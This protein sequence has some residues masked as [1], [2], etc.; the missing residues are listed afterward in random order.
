MLPAPLSQADRNHPQTLS[1]GGDPAPANAP[2]RGLQPVPWVFLEADLPRREG[3]DDQRAEQSQGEALG[4]VYQ[5]C[6]AGGE[7]GRMKSHTAGREGRRGSEPREPAPGDPIIRWP[8][9]GG[10]LGRGLS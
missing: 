5:G 1:R 6:G 7:P 2:R 4:S 8:E 3:Q 9:G 10:E